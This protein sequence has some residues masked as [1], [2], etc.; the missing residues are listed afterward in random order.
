[1]PRFDVL[2]LE[3]E[4]VSE[5]C[6]KSAEAGDHLVLQWRRRNMP[7]VLLESNYFALVAAKMGARLRPSH[8][9]T[10]DAQA[11]ISF[12]PILF[13]SSREGAI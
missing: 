10:G 1:L 6:S 5:R 7:D 13:G 11:G 3:F 12:R 8:S 9:K 2:A 4:R